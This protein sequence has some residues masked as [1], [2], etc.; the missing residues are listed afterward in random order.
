MVKVLLK[1]TVATLISAIPSLAL[2]EYSHLIISRLPSVEWRIFVYSA[3]IATY[4]FIGSLIAR[5]VREFI[6]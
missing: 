2:S 1:V 4:F 5:E 6:D 3:T